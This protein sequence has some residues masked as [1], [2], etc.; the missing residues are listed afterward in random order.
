MDL[1][2]RMRGENFQDVAEALRTMKTSL[3]KATFVDLVEERP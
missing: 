3:A 1:H 2:I